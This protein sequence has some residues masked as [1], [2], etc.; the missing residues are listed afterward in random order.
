MMGKAFRFYQHGG[1]EVMQWEDVDLPPPAAGQVRMRN[2]AVA[3]NYRDVLVRRGSHEVRTFPSGIGLESA[4]VV[5]AVGPGTTDPSVTEI[6]IGDRIACVVGPDGAYAEARNVPAARA[7]K[8]PDGIDERTA[9]AMMIRGMTARYLLHDTYAVKP[10]DV[11]LVHAAAGGVGLI[12]CQWA[13]HL[14]ATVIGTVSSDE[15]ADV[16][17]AHGCDHPIVYTREDFAARVKEITN[18]EGV[19]AVYDSVG[20]TTFDGSLRS[21]RRRGVLASYGEAS[22]DP[23]PVP[24]RRLGQLGSIF[25]THPSLPDYTATRA[26]LLRTANDLFAMVMSGKVKIEISHTYALQNARQAH[27]DLEA[28][29]TTGSIVLT[30]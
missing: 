25:L 1:P 7:V 9:A 15:K 29:K 22:G 6:A 20:R 13:K 18:G 2:T 17:R 26:D 23:E 21:L 8:L 16:A 19:A 30:C 10:G 28:R 3:V 12:L 27:A 24:P 4:G 11:I 5:E 14:G